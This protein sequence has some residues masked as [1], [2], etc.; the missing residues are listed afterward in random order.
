M[1]KRVVVI[2]PGRGS[3]TKE[4]LGY[5]R[6]HGTAIQPFVS[7]IDRRRKELGEPTIT[8]LDNAESFKPQL[9]TRGEHASVLIYSCAYAD[10]A[11][12]DKARFEVV[13]VTGNSMGW[14]ITLALAGSLNWDGAFDVINTMG[15]MM[16]S[17]IIGGQVIYPLVDENWQYSTER[18]Q[19][20]LALVEGLN[21]SGE[22][23]VYP[24]IF[25]GGFI[26][27]GGDKAGLN[28]LLKKLPKIEDYP[29]Q[30][31]NHAAFHTP[32]LRDISKQAFAKLPQS[33][34][35]APQVPMIDGR[36]HIWQSYSTEVEDLYNYTLGH[37]V[38]EPYDFSKALEVSLKEF[39]PDHLVLLGP[40]SSLGGAI[41]Q[42]LVKHNWLN[43]SNKADFIQL[44]KQNP[45]LLSLGLAPQRALLNSSHIQ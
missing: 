27:F 10:F 9:H 44:Q 2:C 36:G 28:R 35:Q 32:L 38:V 31:I 5:L 21:S 17:E 22:G 37:Q 8:E 18:Y 12:I 3:Y 7:H 15:S 4:T 43:I 13:A 40:G 26:V 25:L 23:H 20:V 24:S 42:T 29:F 34:F 41:G 45:F 33:L 11:L 16:K 14:Y 6:Q 19:Q 1:K 30:L 39:C